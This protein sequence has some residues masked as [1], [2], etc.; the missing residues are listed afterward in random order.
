MGRCAIEELFILYIGDFFFILEK[1]G[2]QKKHLG[3]FGG[4]FLSSV[5]LG[6]RKN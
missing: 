5:T 4:E 1:E 6:I 2:S 3:G